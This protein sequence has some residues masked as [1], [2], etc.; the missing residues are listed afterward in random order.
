MS[1][2]SSPGRPLSS[3][4][5]PHPSKKRQSSLPQQH[6]QC[7]TLDCTCVCPIILTIPLVDHHFISL[8]YEMRSECITYPA[9]QVAFDSF[10]ELIARSKSVYTPF[11]RNLLLTNIGHRRRFVEEEIIPPNLSVNLA[12]TGLPQPKRVLHQ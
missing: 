8:K 2:L 7:T 4:R 12:K 3:L 10:L 1:R 9:S 6:P 11:G 5:F